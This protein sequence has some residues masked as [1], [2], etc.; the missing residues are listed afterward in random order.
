[1][2]LQNA[3]QLLNTVAILVLKEHTKPESVMRPQATLTNDMQQQKSLLYLTNQ[4]L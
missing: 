2:S 4:T 3:Q 1:M